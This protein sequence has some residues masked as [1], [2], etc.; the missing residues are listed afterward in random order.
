MTTVAVTWRTL[1]E[2]VRYKPKAEKR[3]ELKSLAGKS[4]TLIGKIFLFDIS[5]HDSLL[6]VLEIPARLRCLSIYLGQRPRLAAKDLV[7]HVPRLYRL[8]EFPNV[9][10]VARSLNSTDQLRETTEVEPDATET[11][12]CCFRVRKIPIEVRIGKI[13]ISKIFSKVS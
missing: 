4:G 3:L 1:S 2:T 6:C 7:F 5:S 9:E 11:I 13:D 8:V 12:Y 10:V